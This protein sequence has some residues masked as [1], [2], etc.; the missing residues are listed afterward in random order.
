MSDKYLEL[1]K[2]II[3]DLTTDE[4]IEIFLFGSR[5]TKNF[6][7][8]SDIDIGLLSKKKVNRKIISR[9]YEELQNSRVPYH[10]DIVD[11]LDVDEK[12]KNA[13]LKNRV[14]WKKGKNIN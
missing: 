5:A 12:F 9:I 6:R 7:W 14:V 1:A 11:F 10:I 13:A 3:L 4:N 2:K 8:N